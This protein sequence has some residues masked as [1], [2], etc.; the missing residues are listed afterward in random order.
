MTRDDAIRKNLSDMLALNRHILEAVERQRGDE[1]V[2][3]RPEVNELVIRIERVIKAHVAGLESMAETY[4]AAKESLLKKAVTG[5]VGAAAGL[6]GK[7]REHERSRMLRDNY[8]ALNLLAI[9]YAMLHTFGLS[10]DESNI[11]DLAHRHL[12]NLPALIGSIRH[13]IP[14]TIAA[15]ILEQ[16]EFTA[17]SD[18]ASR[19]TANLAEIWTDGPLIAS[20]D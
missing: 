7:I 2:R 12:K 15:E 16:N 11:A 8:T 4:G 6:Y 13:A 18:A 10:V 5:A 17:V 14:S 9:S 19:A 1:A 3:E 20:T